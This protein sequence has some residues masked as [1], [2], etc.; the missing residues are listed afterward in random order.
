MSYEPEEWEESLI[1]LTVKEADEYA[2]EASD[3]G[4]HVRVV[5]RDGMP[6][7]VTMDFRMDRLNVETD[8][9]GYITAIVG[10]G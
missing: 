8:A 2:A 3:D 9:D 5:R 1:G 4:T 10:R 7:V 6:L